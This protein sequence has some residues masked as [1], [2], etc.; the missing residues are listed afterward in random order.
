MRSVRTR[1]DDRLRAEA[2]RFSLR[3]ACPDCAWHDQERGACALGFPNEEHA[4]ADLGIGSPPGEEQGPEE[5]TEV[6][7]CK[8]FELG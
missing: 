5:R 4:R 8:T 6:V 7:F 3:F 2:S 1:I